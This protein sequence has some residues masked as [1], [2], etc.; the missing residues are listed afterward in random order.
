MLGHT[1]KKSGVTPLDSKNIGIRAHE[2]KTKYTYKFLIRL[3]YLGGTY[4][5]AVRKF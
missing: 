1:L 5:P 4:I 3:N 2:V